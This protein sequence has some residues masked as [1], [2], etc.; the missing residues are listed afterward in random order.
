MNESNRRIVLDAARDVGDFLKDKLPPVPGLEKRN[1]YA[2]V[3]HSIKEK[4]GKSYKDCDDSDVQNILDF[5]SQLK[6][7]I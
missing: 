5:L 6:S 4:F 2:H 7:S 3:Y 1:S